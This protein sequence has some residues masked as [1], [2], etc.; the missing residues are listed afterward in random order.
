MT[1]HDQETGEILEDLIPGRQD[2]LGHEI[3]DPRPMQVPAG[4]KR[5]ET[6]QE[7]VARLVRGAISREAEE[8]GFE[9]FDESEDF[10]VDDEFDPRT[11]F[12]TVFDPVLGEVT[13][14]DL[15]KFEGEYRNKYMALQQAAFEAEDKAA[16]IASKMKAFSE[17]AIS[18]F[19]PNSPPRRG[20][21]RSQGSG[22][23]PLEDN[24]PSPEAK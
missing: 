13:P 2:G 23:D 22:T 17:A 5:P 19:R 12:E 15:R 11:P 20:E 18:N 3:P 16:L 7:Q 10:D 6:L 21:A 8:A 9:T 4:M 14:H 1:V 24:K